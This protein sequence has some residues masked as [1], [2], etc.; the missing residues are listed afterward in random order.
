[1]KRLNT[2]RFFLLYNREPKLPDD[3]DVEYCIDEMEGEEP[4]YEE[5]TELKTEDVLNELT[6]EKRIKQILNIHSSVFSE[7]AQNILK[8]QKKQ[9]KYFKKR[10]SSKS[11]F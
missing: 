10:H 4:K 2:L 7:T 11:T 9:K 3:V 6:F 8:G 5:C 1:M